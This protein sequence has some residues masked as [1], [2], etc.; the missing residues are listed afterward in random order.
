MLNSKV[1]FGWSYNFNGSPDFWNGRSDE[2]YSL[3]YVDKSNQV[4]QVRFSEIYQLIEYVRLNDIEF[5]KLI[6]EI[7]PPCSIAMKNYTYQYF[8]NDLILKAVRSL[9]N[10]WHSQYNVID[11]VK[12]PEND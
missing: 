4:K 1:L 7:T 12:S 11:Q 8:E 9:S 6:R 3:R 5:G 2:D 10:P